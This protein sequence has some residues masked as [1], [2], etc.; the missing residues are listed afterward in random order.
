MDAF[1]KSFNLQRKSLQALR[2]TGIGIA[3]AKEIVYLLVAAGTSCCCGV[4]M[5][6]AREGPLA[7]SILD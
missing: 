4:W 1:R 6:G 7:W 5:V 3:F 2:V